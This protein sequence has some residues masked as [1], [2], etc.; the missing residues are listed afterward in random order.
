M[1]VGCSSETD[2][3]DRG[4]DALDGRCR[5]VLS[6]CRS[7]AAPVGVRGRSEE[8]TMGLFLRRRRPL[9]RLAAGAA[10]GGVAYNAGRRREEQDMGKDQARAASAATQAPPPAPAAAPAAP[11]PA[12]DPTSELERL[13]Q[14]HASGSLTDDEFTAA[15]ARLLRV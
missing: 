13:A 1:I 2:D 5:C 8:V 11:G 14:L 9:M 7:L 4:Y 12:A 3:A 6:G 15:K 10:V